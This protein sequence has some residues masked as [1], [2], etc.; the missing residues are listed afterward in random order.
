MK[1]II[2]YLL[3]LVSL[4]GCSTPLKIE[5]VQKNSKPNA[6]EILQRSLEIASLEARLNEKR[7]KRT[8]E[9][10]RIQIGSFSSEQYELDYVKR[11]FNKLEIKGNLV[12]PA[13]INGMYGKGRFVFRLKYD[14][15]LLFT[16]IL[17]SSGHSEL[18]E[19]MLQVI[20]S[21][22]PFEPFPEEIKRK[23]HEVDILKT[24]RFEKT[25]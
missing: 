3:F 17:K 14:G 8:P 11:C 24:F 1:I 2:P 5:P 16:K 7:S 6:L 15:S 18:D 19:F 10:T 25:S 21:S 9:D 23:A 20:K 4:V 13:N 12:H 22:A